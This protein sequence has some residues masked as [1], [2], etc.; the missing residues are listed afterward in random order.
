LDFNQQSL[1]SHG[2][3][4]HLAKQSISFSSG[5]CSMIDSILEIFLGGRKWSCNLITVQP[6]NATEKKPY[7]TS[8]GHAPLQWNAGT[9][10]APVVKETSL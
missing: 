6:W 1:S 10:S 3:G 9:L 2:F 5:C 4:N 8:F 7:N